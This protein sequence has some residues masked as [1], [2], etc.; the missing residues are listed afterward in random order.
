MS[1]ELF[2]RCAQL[3][4]NAQV[5]IVTTGAGMSVD[6]GLPDYRGK[7][8]LWNVWG[9]MKKAKLRTFL[10]NPKEAWS[11]QAQRIEIFRRTEPHNG[12]YLLKKW[13]ERYNLDYFLITTNID[14][15]FQK[16]GFPEDKI[17]EIHGSTFY[18]QCFDKCCDKVWRNTLQFT[19]HE[20]T[21]LIEK[22]P[23][24]PHCSKSIARPNALYFDDP[25]F[26]ETRRNIQDDNYQ[27]FLKSIGDKR[28]V[29]FEVGAGTA[30]TTIRA[31][32]EFYG[33]KYSNCTIIRMNPKNP[34][35]AEPHI[36]IKMGALEAF[37]SIEAAIV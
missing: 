1:N 2:Q 20:E 37:E 24:C 18:L 31:L 30:V 27:T 15:Q 5:L 19:F 25:N 3:V 28:V 17:R 16:T 10:E 29:V 12:Y 23:M 22:I 33:R 26:I 35:I 7:K 6:C 9:N 8:G 32:S 34:E 14:N 36:S 21:N 11:F 4:K 13:I